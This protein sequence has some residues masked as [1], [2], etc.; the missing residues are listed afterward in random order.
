MLIKPLGNMYMLKHCIP[1]TLLSKDL[2]SST[3]AMKWA[4]I[5]TFYFMHTP[6]T[7]K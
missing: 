6:N 5:H 1:I 3:N 2:V 4:F 7:K